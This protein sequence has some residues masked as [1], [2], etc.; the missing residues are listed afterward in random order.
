MRDMIGTIAST[1]ISLILLALIGVYVM[2][3]NKGGKTANFVSAVTFVQTKAREGFAQSNVGYTNFTT[4][5]AGNL[6][7]GGDFPSMLLRGGVLVDTWGNNMQLSSTANGTQGVISFGGGGSEDV[8]QCK[9]VVL[10][11][12]DYVTLNVGGTTFTQ[13]NQPDGN[14]ATTA[15]GAGTASI[16]LT[17]S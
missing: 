10:G 7:N 9:S 6:A 16:S 15:C 8:E 5:N 12:K 11:F 4:A 3:G 2:S 17:F 14:S 13:T 1:V